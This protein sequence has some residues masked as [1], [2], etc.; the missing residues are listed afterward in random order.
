MSDGDPGKANDGARG[1]NWP[2][3]MDDGAAR[4]RGLAI[5]ASVV[6]LMLAVGV[7]A[8]VG[9][10]PPDAP[11]QRASAP[12]AAPAPSAAPAPPP[13]PPAPAILPASA[14]PAPDPPPPATSADIAAAPGATTPTDWSQIPIDDVR[15]RAE[16]GDTAAMD[17]LAQRLI[18]GIGVTRDQSAG[19]G[20]LLRA[21]QSGSGQAAFN[22]GVMYERGFVVARDSTKAVEWYRRAVEAN[23]PTAKHNL[24]LLLRDGK[25]AARSG[26]EA[27]DLLRSAARQGMAAS[28]FTLGDTYERGDVVPKDPPLALAW[29]AITAEFER[30]ANRGTETTLAKTATQ[31]AQVLQRALTPAELERAQ[32][33]GRTEFR[34]IV[35]ALQAA[36]IVPRPPSRAAP[37]AAPA[38]PPEPDPPGWPRTQSE[39]IAAIQQALL[40]LKLLRDKPDGAIGPV[41]RTAIRD[42]QRAQGLR[43]TGESSRELFVALREAIAKRDAAGA[44]ALPPPAPTPPAAPEPKPEAKAEPP[45]PEPAKVEPPDPDAWPAAAPDQI[46][47]I[48]AM[49]RDLKFYNDT[50][51]GLLGPGTRGAIRAFERAMGTREIGEPG[52][53][54]FDQLK[55]MRDLTAPKRP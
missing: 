14:I 20:W 7:A 1:L 16:G 53:A 48:Q 33:V 47:A 46:K 40:D 32:S 10:S 22:V 25:G 42:F 23:V 24:A 37:V 8:W 30:Q 35:E 26:R 15:A 31:R 13:T 17:E 4:R 2:T 44:T 19:A 38:P 34:E 52:R 36:G 55:E 41:T 50:V 3:P 12:P 11:P 5:G 9:Y 49:L 6:V 39:Q 29:F 45:K 43:E 27:V 18:Q 54:V 21:A 51:D 28:M